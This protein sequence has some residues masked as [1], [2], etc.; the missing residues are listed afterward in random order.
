MPPP[1]PA[2]PPPS[3]PAD[4]IG[5]G[6]QTGAAEKAEGSQQAACPA[7]TPCIPMPTPCC[8][9]AGLEGERRGSPVPSLPAPLPSAAPSPAPPPGPTYPRGSGRGRAARPPARSQRRGRSA[10]SRGKLPGAGKAAGSTAR[11][12]PGRGTGAAPAGVSISVSWKAGASAARPAPG[13]ERGGRPAG[14]KRGPGSAP[15]P[16]SALVA[17]RRSLAGGTGEPLPTAPRVPRRI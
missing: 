2:A 1:R 13:A 14:G 6:D 15:V 17:P 3:P 5:A 4:R 9:P 8:Q 7:I 11:S 10:G 16:A 12:R